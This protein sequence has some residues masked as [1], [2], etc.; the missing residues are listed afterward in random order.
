MRRALR[1]ADRQP[2]CVLEAG[3]GAGHG[4]SWLSGGRLDFYCKGN[5]GTLERVDDEE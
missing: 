2:P 3:G 5:G 4:R 1:Q